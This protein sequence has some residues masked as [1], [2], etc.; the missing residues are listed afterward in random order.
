MTSILVFIGVMVFQ[1]AML[2]F[3]ARQARLTG[4]AEA[5]RELSKKRQEIFQTRAGKAQAVVEV[6]G[7][8]LKNL[9][10]RYTGKHKAYEETGEGQVELAKMTHRHAVLCGR[11]KEAA[12]AHKLMIDTWTELLEAAKDVAE[13][14]QK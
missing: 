7:T 12:A 5:L 13:N 4:R 8:R 2:I 1:V 6:I 14:K 3:I 11:M 9:T 10:T